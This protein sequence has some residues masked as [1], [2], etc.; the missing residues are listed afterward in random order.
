MPTPNPRPAPRAPMPAR[1]TLLTFRLWG[2]V[3]AL[4]V[5]RVHEIIDPLPTTVVPRADAF[6]PGLINVRG[7]VVPVVDLRQRLAMP[8]AETTDRSRMVVLDV[9]IGDGLIKV[10]LVAD[11]VEQVIELETARI[12]PVPEIGIRWP[13]RY[14]AG[15]ARREGDLL[16]LLRPDTLFE[17]SAQ[18]APRTA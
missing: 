2:E 12:E 6:V 8:P 5:E 16:I 3:F 9:E 4:A 1:Q 18:H 11:S 17:P 13:V 10:A 15:V 14:L 7:S